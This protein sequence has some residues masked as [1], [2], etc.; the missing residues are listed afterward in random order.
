MIDLLELLID[1]AT[2]FSKKGMSNVLL[3]LIIAAILLVVALMFIS[4]QD[5]NANRIFDR[6]TCILPGAC[7]E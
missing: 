4:A 3:G 5:D 6:I 7:R 1:N 2:F